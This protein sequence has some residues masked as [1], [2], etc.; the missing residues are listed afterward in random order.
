MI[1]EQVLKF[2]FLFLHQPAT[3]QIDCRKLLSLEFYGNTLTFHNYKITQ[4]YI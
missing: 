3:D 4:Q 2:D 1:V